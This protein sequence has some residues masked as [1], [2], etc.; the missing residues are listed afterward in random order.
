M[1]DITPDVIRRIQ[2][3]FSGRGVREVVL[4]IENG[5]LIVLAVKRTKIE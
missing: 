4:R 2:A 1:I 3:A 5:K